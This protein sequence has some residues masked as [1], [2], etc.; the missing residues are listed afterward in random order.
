MGLKNK[1]AAFGLNHAIKKKLLGSTETEFLN[2]NADGSK[3]ALKR[4]RAPG[5]GNTSHKRAKTEGMD[6]GRNVKVEDSDEVGN[7]EGTESLTEKE[8]SEEVG[9][10][11]DAV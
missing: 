7:E 10:D 6:K 1:Q 8:G 11:E 9:G 3:P 5:A 4:G 2:S